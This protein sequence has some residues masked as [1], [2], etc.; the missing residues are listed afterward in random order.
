MNRRENLLQLLER[1]NEH[2]EE[3]RAAW[4]SDPDGPVTI[5]SSLA[6]NLIAEV[7]DVAGILNSNIDLIAPEGE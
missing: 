6:T 5:T 7:R 2:V 1:V 4:Q 3:L